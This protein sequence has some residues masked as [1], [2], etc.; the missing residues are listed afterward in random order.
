MHV[1][2]HWEEN[3]IR[4]IESG[5]ESED[6]YDN[7]QFREMLPAYATSAEPPTTS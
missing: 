7:D 6:H 4:N 2:M 5:V 3:Q 1:V